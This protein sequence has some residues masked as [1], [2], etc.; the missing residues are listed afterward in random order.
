MIEIQVQGQKQLEEK[1][2]LLAGALDT[3]ALLDQSAALL[4]NNIRRRFLQQVDS[5][6]NR[7]EPSRASLIRAAK[8][9][10][11]GTLFD[12]GT[13][14]HSIQVSAVGPTGRA[15]KTNVNYAR[16]HNEGLLG[17]IRREFLAFGDRDVD[18]VKKLIVKRVVEA[19]SG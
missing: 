2:K 11:G 18:L 6:G 1:V 8:G 14:F 4:L 19:L 3:T 13:M 7:W 10:D 9:R 12:T 15:I 5:S 16:K 17:N